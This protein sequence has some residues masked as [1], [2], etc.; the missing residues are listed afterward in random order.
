LTSRLLA[1]SRRQ[2]L[3]PK[4]VNLNSFLSGLQEFLQRTLGERIEVQTVGGAGLWNIEAEVNHLE[5][6][7]VNLAINARDAMPNG[8]KLTIE[9]ANVSVDDD[10]SRANPE[11]AAGQYVIIS[12]SDTGSGMTPEVLNHAFEPFFTTNEPGQGTGLGLSQVYG[13]VKQSGGHVKIYS[14]VGRVSASRCI[15]PATSAMRSPRPTM[16]MNSYLKAF[17]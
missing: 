4:P 11:V 16:R 17:R 9:A 5:S 13:F 15:F 1:F 8:G 2:A 3:D 6:T 7:I 10:Y 14:E 12:V